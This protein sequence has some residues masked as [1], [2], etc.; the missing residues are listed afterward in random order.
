[1]LCTWRPSLFSLPQWRSTDTYIE[2]CPTLFFS[3]LFSPCVWICSQCVLSKCKRHSFSSVFVY[4]WLKYSRFR[5]ELNVEVEASEEASHFPIL[6]GCLPQTTDSFPVLGADL[7][8]NS[9]CYI[10]ADFFCVPCFF[11]RLSSVFLLLCPSYLT[12][13]NTD[14]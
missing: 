6:S 10:T 2:R 13:Y 7:N 5:L 9:M 8:F 14:R 12:H 11:S 4:T 1:M 3:S